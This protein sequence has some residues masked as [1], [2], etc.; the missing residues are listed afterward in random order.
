MGKINLD[1]PYRQ[2]W[3]A[4]TERWL[5]RNGYVI[6]PE[7]NEKLT[8]PRCGITEIYKK[9]E[10]NKSQ[11]GYRICPKCYEDEIMRDSL[12]I[13]QIDTQYWYLFSHK[14]C[15]SMG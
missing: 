13:D 14:N 9:S 11:F 12:G 7:E 10:I 6:N 8:C 3:Y 4:E 5:K 15:S 1:N 2:K